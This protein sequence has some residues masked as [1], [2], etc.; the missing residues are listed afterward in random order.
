[1][2]RDYFARYFNFYTTYC[3]E[4]TRFY[5]AFL[6][7]IRDIIYYMRY[8]GVEKCLSRRPRIGGGVIHFT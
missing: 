8:M 3:L 4:G 1:M 5:Y 7:N 6:I 2:S